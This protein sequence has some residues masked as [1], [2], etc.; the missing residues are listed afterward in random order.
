M[1]RKSSADILEKFNERREEPMSPFSIQLHL[2]A[3]HPVTFHAWIES[4]FGKVV[5]KGT[6]FAEVSGPNG[7]GQIVTNGEMFL[8]SHAEFT[9]GKV[10]NPGD[11]VSSGAADGEKI[12]Y[13]KPYCVFIPTN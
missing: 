7:R 9:S 6:P 4:S 1:S 10:L 8:S 5:E 12:P 2:G 3:E 13:G 11:Y